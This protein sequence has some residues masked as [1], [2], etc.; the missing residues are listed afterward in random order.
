MSFIRYTNTWTVCLLTRL[1]MPAC[2]QAQSRSI[3]ELVTGMRDNLHGRE[4]SQTNTP[5]SSSES[6]AICDWGTWH[7]AAN[8]AGLNVPMAPNTGHPKATGLLQQDKLAPTE[9]SKSQPSTAS[10]EMTDPGL[11]TCIKDRTA[12]SAKWMTWTHQPKA[13]TIP[14]A[15]AKLSLQALH[16]P[17]DTKYSYLLA[18]SPALII[19]HQGQDPM[20]T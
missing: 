3:P 19:V 13:I 10:G 14:S 2:T 8:S 15:Y 7:C 11:P 12:S 5:E 6:P 18:I 1:C 16:H 17:T 9:A 20:A 4:C